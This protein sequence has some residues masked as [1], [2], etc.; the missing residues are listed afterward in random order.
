MSRILLGACGVAIGGF[1]PERDL[2][3][4]P[5]NYGALLPVASLDSRPGAH[6]GG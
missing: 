6:Y 3:A 1:V 4:H 5:Q 2:G